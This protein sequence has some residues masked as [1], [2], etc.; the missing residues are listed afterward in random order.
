MFSEEISIPVPLLV[1]EP[2]LPLCSP[3]TDCPSCSLVH[4]HFQS[5]AE[6]F[7]PESISHTTR[8]GAPQLCFCPC[9]GGILGLYTFHFPVWISGSLTLTSSWDLTQEL[10]P[11][12][13]VCVAQL[14][15]TLL[16]WSHPPS[17]PYPLHPCSCQLH[18]Y[19]PG[20]PGPK[21]Q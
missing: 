14:T 6:N 12:W 16:N 7:L 19:L 13:S 11:S 20:H 18:H 21:L 3:S 15:R 10:Q 17:P 5:R 8:V 2:F 4:F 9:R 1:S